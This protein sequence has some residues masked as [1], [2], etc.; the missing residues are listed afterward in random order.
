MGWTCGTY[1]EQEKCM[2]DFGEGAPVKKTNWKSYCV[3]SSRRVKRNAVPLYRQGHTP[4]H[5]NPSEP[6]CKTIEF[7]IFIAEFNSTSSSVFEVV[8][9]RNKRPFGLISSE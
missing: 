2:Q 1:R 8:Y 9:L 6:S 4:E 5:L 3:T 7:L